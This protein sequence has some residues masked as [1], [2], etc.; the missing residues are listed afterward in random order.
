MH[1]YHESGQISTEN[2]L[3]IC[4]ELTELIRH[5]ADKVEANTPNYLLYY[6][7]LLLMN[8]NVLVNTASQQ[9]LFVPFTMLSYYVTHDSLTCKQAQDYL[10][11][12]LQQSKLLNSSGEKEKKAFFGKMFHKI[13]T[14]QQ[15]ITSQQ[16][17]DFE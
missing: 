13:K 16:F 6:N 2:A 1:F 11:K 12:Q 5:I 14:L 7:E 17:L 4:D 8:N 9:L 15:L 10:Q 3:L